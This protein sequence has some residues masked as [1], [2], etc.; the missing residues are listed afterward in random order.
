MWKVGIS[1]VAKFLWWVETDFDKTRRDEKFRWYK[2]KI[3]DKP[4]LRTS[5]SRQFE[6]SQSSKNL[7]TRQFV[8]LSPQKFR[9]ET[10]IETRIGSR[11]VEKSR[12]DNSR[13]T[14][15]RCSDWKLSKVCKCVWEAVDFWKNCKK[16][17]TILWKFSRIEK[18]YHL[19]NTLW[20][21]QH[22]IKSTPFQ[23]YSH[24]L[25]TIL[26]RNILYATFLTKHQMSQN[27]FEKQSTFSK[28]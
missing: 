8:T 11:K 5:A 14:P 17:L 7:K 19:S 15:T 22:R 24:I 18:I 2:K 4:R 1:H 25:L 3:R 16:R 13:P 21:Y 28:L 27:A 26:N 6:T 12:R 10:R 23:F 20:L 9:D